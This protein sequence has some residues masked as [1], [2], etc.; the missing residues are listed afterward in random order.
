MTNREKS[1]WERYLAAERELDDARWA[2]MAAIN[3]LHPRARA[4]SDGARDTLDR[5]F[6]V[7][8]TLSVESDA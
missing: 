3:A 5:Q 2:L 6:P 7:T 8:R 1:A 4:A